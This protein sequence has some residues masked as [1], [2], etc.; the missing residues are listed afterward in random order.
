MKKKLIVFFLILLFFISHFLNSNFLNINLLTRAQAQSPVPP[1]V[2]E[3]EID[4]TN[5]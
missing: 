2:Q 3:V 5:F 1:P 4:L